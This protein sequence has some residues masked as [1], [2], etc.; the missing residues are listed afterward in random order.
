MKE[1]EAMKLIDRCSRCV[2]NG[3]TDNFRSYEEGVKDALSWIFCGSDKPVVFDE[4][5]E[6]NEQ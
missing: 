1:K 2:E 5:E 3:T 6:R 4:E